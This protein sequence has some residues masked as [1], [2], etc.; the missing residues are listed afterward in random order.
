MPRSQ[1]VHDVPGRDAEVRAATAERK[2]KRLRTENESLRR[3]LGLCEEALNVAVQQ[4]KL[5]ARLAARTPQF[6]D[7]LEIFEV[8]RMRDRILGKAV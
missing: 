4:R 8:E 7:P 3:K 2:L 5:M 6:S 1:S